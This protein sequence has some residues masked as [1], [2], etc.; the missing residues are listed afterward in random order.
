M[1][2][3]TFCSVELGSSFCILCDRFN[4]RFRVNDAAKLGLDRLLDLNF[5]RFLDLNFDHLFNWFDTGGSWNLPRPFQTTWTDMPTQTQG[6]SERNSANLK[7]ICQFAADFINPRRFMFAVTV[8]AIG[9]G[10][11]SQI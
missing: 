4:S 3:S 5:D 1:Y 7:Q 9:T 10:P 2:I 6:R 11:S 8:K